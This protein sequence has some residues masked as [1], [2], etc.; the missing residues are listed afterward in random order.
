[1]N[2][3]KYFGRRARPY[4]GAACFWL[5]QSAMPFGL[6]GTGGDRSQRCDAHVW[7]LDY[8]NALAPQLHKWRIHDETGPNTDN[9]GS[10][11]NSYKLPWIPGAPPAKCWPSII[12]GKKFEVCQ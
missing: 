9:I 7:I 4:L 11:V 2:A 8:A 5:S 10:E 1:M 3:L 12:D 6:M